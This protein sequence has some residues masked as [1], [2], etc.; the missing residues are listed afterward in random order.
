MDGEQ[1]MTEYIR[2]ACWT[3]IFVTIVAAICIGIA[4][5]WK[6]NP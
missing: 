5:A 1:L 6:P 2:R 3:V 4:L